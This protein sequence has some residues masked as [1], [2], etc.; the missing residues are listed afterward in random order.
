MGGQALN[1]L[2]L[3]SPE[4]HI[5]VFCKGFNPI[6]FGLKDLQNLRLPTDSLL[7]L[8]ARHDALPNCFLVLGI[9]DHSHAHK[10]LN[11][12][13]SQLLADREVHHAKVLRQEF[14]L[15]E[16]DVGY[17]RAFRVVPCLVNPDLL[18][19]IGELDETTLDEAHLRG[20]NACSCSAFLERQWCGGTVVAKSNIHLVIVSLSVDE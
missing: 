1:A 11:E 18:G 12:P 4:V 14:D 9:Q 8:S 17:P 6:F 19:L 20:C 10:S 5:K 15:G 7:D 16:A 13:A 3:A 2:D